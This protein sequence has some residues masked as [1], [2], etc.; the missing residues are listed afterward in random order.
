VFS[1]G[2]AGYA[3]QNTLLMEHLASHGY[4][5]LAPFH[6]HES[7]THQLGDGTVVTQS[8]RMMSEMMQLATM[9]T[10]DYMKVFLGGCSLPERLDIARTEVKKLRPIWL[11]ATAHDRMRDNV[12]IVDC[13]EDG[14]VP[15][16]AQAL[17]RIAD[18]TRLGYFGMSYGG[19]VAALCCLNDPRA[20]AGINIDG[21]FF[22]AEVLGREIG[23]PF[24]A[25]TEDTS[26]MAKQVKMDVTLAADRPSMLDVLYERIDGTVPAAPMHRVSLRGMAHLSFTDLPWMVRGQEGLQHL[27]GAV[28]PET[29]IAVQRSFVQDFFDTYLQ[30]KG[31]QFPQAAAR[32]FAD[33]AVIHDRNALLERERRSIDAPRPDQRRED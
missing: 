5:V 22:T 23:V 20:R 4:V 2:G 29:T 15:E 17:A 3:H 12:F 18:T 28:T 33:V 16:T 25:L 11:G 14:A 27:V 13:V 6:P 30:G 21:G 32:E 7:W 31:R 19:H 26:V 10:P 9:V 8:P 24:L 1:H